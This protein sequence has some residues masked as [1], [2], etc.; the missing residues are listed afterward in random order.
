MMLNGA[1]FSNVKVKQ[2]YDPQ[3]PNQADK[4]CHSAPISQ[5]AV[6]MH[7]VSKDYNA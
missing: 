5:L 4:L 2:I 3:A 7:E 1:F 6:H